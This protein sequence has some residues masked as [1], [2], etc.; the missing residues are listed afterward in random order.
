MGLCPKPRTPAF[1]SEKSGAKEL[2]F[3]F[4]CEFSCWNLWHENGHGFAEYIF[5]PFVSLVRE[6][7]SGAQPL[8]GLFIW[9]SA[10][11]PARF[12]EKSV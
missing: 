11:Y 6:Y 10:P 1:L 3:C 5:C 7:C 2:E 9:G 12:F 8:G 4:F